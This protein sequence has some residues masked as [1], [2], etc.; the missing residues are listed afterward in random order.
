MKVAEEALTTEK[1]ETR[2]VHHN[3]YSEFNNKLIGSPRKSENCR[4]I[5]IEAL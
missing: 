2:Y 5:A 1:K 4:M 3:T